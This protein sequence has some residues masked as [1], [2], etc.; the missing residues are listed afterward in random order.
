MEQNKLEKRDKK[1]FWQCFFKEWKSMCAFCRGKTPM[2]TLPDAPP[3]FHALSTPGWSHS[4]EGGLW[5]KRRE[6]LTSQSQREEAR[7]RYHRYRTI[8]TQ[9]TSIRQRVASTWLKTLLPTECKPKHASQI[10]APASIIESQWH[11]FQVNSFWQPKA[12]IHLTGHQFFWHDIV[13]MEIIQ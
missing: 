3:R 8:L 11:S 4:R 10:H 1:G 12:S 7:N 13:N 9:E 6:D 5:V 2:A